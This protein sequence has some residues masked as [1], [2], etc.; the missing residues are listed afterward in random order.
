VSAPDGIGRLFG[1]VADLYDDMRPAYPDE[2]FD[3]IEDVVGHFDGL[4]VLDLAAGTGLQTR[5]LAG[6]GARVFAVDPDVGML[7]RLCAK[8]PGVPAVAGRGEQIP[9][10][11]NSSELVVCATA[12]HWLRT[13]EAIEEIRRVLRPGGHLALWWA[14][15]EWGDGIAWED[16]Q[17]EVFERWD[18]VRGSVPPTIDGVVAREAADDLRRRGL[19]VVLEQDFSWTRDVTREEH[20]RLL[21]THSNNL[22]LPESDRRELLAEIETALQPW[23]VVTERLRGPLI[24]AHF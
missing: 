1:T 11:D 4:S 12:W 23:P 2:L 15:N 8:A 5:V 10:R 6:R 18:S 9:L 7:R 24:V 16:A 20:L 21:A 13:A 17:S 3:T 22:A 14:N 19:E